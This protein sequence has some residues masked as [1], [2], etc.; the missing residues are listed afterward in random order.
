M[1][2]PCMVAVTNRLRSTFVILSGPLRSCVNL[3]KTNHYVCFH[4][5]MGSQTDIQF[6]QEG[7]L[8]FKRVRLPLGIHS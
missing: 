5:F 2:G 7:W 3:A 8:Y 4:I 1:G 6:L